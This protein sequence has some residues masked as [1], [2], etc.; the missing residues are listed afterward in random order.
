MKEV[1]KQ[2]IAEFHQEPIPVP[3]HRF[4]EMPQ[5]P[6]NVR[7]AVVYIGMR[8]SGKT[9]ALYQQMHAL[10][11]QGIQK[12]QLLYIN[13]EDDRLNGMKV[14]DL[15][16][17]V[18][19]YWELYPDQMESYSLH[20]FLDEIAEIEGW[21]SFIRRLLDKEKMQLYLSGSSAKMLSKEIATN[22]R[23]RTITREIFPLSFQEYAQYKKFDI[24]KIITTKQRSQCYY[25]INQYLT[26]GGFPEVLEANVMLHRE[27]LQSYMDSVIYR[28]IVERHDVKN[29]VVLRQLLLFCLQNPAT[30][31]SVNKLFQQFKSR[32]ISVSK[33]SLYQYLSYFEDA[34]CLFEVPVYSFSLAKASLK[35][36]KIY[37]IDTGLITAYSIKPGYTQGAILETAVFLHLR[38]NYQE[39]F[40]YQTALGKEVDF[41][42]VDP[43]GQMALYQVSLQMA[44]AATRQREIVAMEQAMIE[45][46][47]TQGVIVT[48]LES[49]EVSVVSGS[50]IVLP[51]WQFLRSDEYAKK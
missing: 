46:K 8:R 29:H 32:G 11:A 51:L 5:L 12:H 39:I 26:W 14:H 22:L 18:E 16:F 4:V 25:L 27:L 36:K 40:Y 21:E 6:E 31:L 33:N 15:Q 41:L 2:I 30:L 24:K 50:I 7:K 3:A 10:M 42:T 19:A 34:Y 23:G 37:P 1:I 45:L 44:D 9:W 48:M 47:L 43:S 17:I 38:R 35:P 28:D 13:F 49:E 20:F